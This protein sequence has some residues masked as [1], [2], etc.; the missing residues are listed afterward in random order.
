[1]PLELLFIV[2][3]TLFVAAIIHGSIGFGF[4]LIATPIIALFTDMQTA[5]FFTLIPTLLVNIVSIKSE[6]KFMTVFKEFAPFAIVSTLGSLI[7]TI[8]LISLNSEFFKLLLAVIILLYL[9]MDKFKVKTNVVHKHPK[10][11]LVFFG[12]SAGLMGGLTNAMAPLLIV[13][14]FESNHTKSQTIQFSN[15]CFLF[16]KIVQLII[17]SFYASFTHVQ[18]GFSLTTLFVVALALFVGVK[19]K[20]KIEGPLYKLCIKGLLFIMAVLLIVQV[21]V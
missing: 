9:S 10:K 13:Y 19:I 3:A 2:A 15:L 20:R 1:M 12:L 18:M 6:E 14:S 16:G 7:G 5:V 8:I 21:S 4:P 17:F 11:S